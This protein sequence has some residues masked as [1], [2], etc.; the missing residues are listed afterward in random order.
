[1]SIIQRPLQTAKFH[2]C[3][4]QMWCVRIRWDPRDRDP[5]IVRPSGYNAKVRLPRQ[6]R[7]RA[8][9][10]RMKQNLCRH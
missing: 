8:D 5:N 9:H 1:M 3:L 4:L 2:T 10:G 6:Q 7:L